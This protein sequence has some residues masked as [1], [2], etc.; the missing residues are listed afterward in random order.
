MDT[1]LKAARGEAQGFAIK[2]EVKLLEVAL[3]FGIE[4]EGR[5]AKDIAI[6]VGEKAMNEFGNRTESL[7]I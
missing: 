6:E 2:D 4:I 3:D 7:F 5:P 1:F